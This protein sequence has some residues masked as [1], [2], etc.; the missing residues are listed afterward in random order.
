MCNRGI[1]KSNKFL[2]N[3]SNQP[4]KYRAKNWVEVKDDSHGTNNTNSQIKF[5]TSM[6]KSNLCDY[7]DVNIFV[8]GIISDKNTSS[9]G[10]DVNN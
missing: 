7:S 10:A 9:T 5:K 4:S 3:T 2:G 8:K 6:L 1:L